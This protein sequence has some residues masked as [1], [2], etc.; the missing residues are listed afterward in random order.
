MFGIVEN[1]K[2]PYMIDIRIS[3]TFFPI[4]ICVMVL[5]VINGFLKGVSKFKLYGF[6]NKL[7]RKHGRVEEILIRVFSV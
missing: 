3:N 1:C 5:D 7:F 4:T 2:I 6:M